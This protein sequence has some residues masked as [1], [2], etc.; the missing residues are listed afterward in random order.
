MSAAGVLL[1]WVQVLFLMKPMVVVVC[2]QDHM[3]Q[4]PAHVCLFICSVLRCMTQTLNPKS[5]YIYI[6]IYMYTCIHV[7]MYTCIHVYM[8]TCIHT[9]IHT[10]R[11]TDRQTYIRI[12][13]GS[14]PR[15]AKN[16]PLP[17]EARP[18]QKR[19]LRF[20]LSVRLRAWFGV[21]ELLGS[22]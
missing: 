9:Y 6:Y 4:H 18:T 12:C 15:F 3:R 13:E 2:Y 1:L 21:W 16:P 22:W 19:R 11:Q 20:T 8:Y 17:F 10:D 14:R 7:Y 5:S